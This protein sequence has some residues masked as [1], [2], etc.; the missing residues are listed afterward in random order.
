MIA[1]RPT[2]LAA[3]A[4]LAFSTTSLHAEDKGLIGIAMPTKSSSRW[5][6]DGENLKKGFEARGYQVDLQYA[7]DDIPTQ[8]AQIESM[9]TK[10]ARALV[11]APR[12][13][14]PR[15]PTSCRKPMTARSRC[16]PMTG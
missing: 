6:S 16:S 1:R 8:L 12:S 7:E 3:L 13:T 4:A 11:I 14:A 9:V 2:L 10:G 5:I 15:S